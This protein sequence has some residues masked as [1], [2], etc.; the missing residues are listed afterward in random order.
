MIHPVEILFWSVKGDLVQILK[1]RS[2]QKWQHPTLLSWA[3]VWQV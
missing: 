3:A 2:E 1:R